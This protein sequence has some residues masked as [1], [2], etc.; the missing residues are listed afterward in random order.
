MSSDSDS[1]DLTSYSDSSLISSNSIEY[2]E[3]ESRVV[4]YNQ[5]TDRILENVIIN[6]PNLIWIWHAL[7]GTP[8]SCNDINVL[9]R[10]PVFSDVLK[11]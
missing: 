6:Y 11:G 2:H 1:E 8:R 9:H 4:Q 7:F 3:W 10:S 5:R